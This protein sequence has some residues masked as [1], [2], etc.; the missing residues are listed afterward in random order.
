MVRGCVQQRPRHLFA[1]ASPSGKSAVTN[2]VVFKCQ[3]CPRGKWTLGKAGG[4]CVTK[5]LPPTPAPKKATPKPTP[6]REFECV[7][8]KQLIFCI[9]IVLP[10]V[11]KH[12]KCDW[13][14]A[15]VQI[16]T[17]GLIEDH[18]CHYDPQSKRYLV[19]VCSRC[20]SLVMQMSLYLRN[21]IFCE[22]VMCHVRYKNVK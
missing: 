2:G 5:K 1:V 11:C 21:L 16:K 22:C 20:S 3:L 10:H 18:D 14:G 9:A 17:D 13:D 7:F 6:M 12:T 4:M 15:S 8:C 19:V